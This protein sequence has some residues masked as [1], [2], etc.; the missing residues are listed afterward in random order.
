MPTSQYHFSTTPE[1]Q[2]YTDE[3][4][5]TKLAADKAAK[6]AKKSEVRK[7]LLAMLKDDQTKKLFYASMILCVAS[8]GLAIASPWFLKSVVDSM[9]LGT[10]VNLNAAF[11]GVGA[12]GLTRLL[13]TLIQEARMWD[14][15]K[16]IQLST[17]RIS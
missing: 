9:A 12:F 17:K 6:A 10:Q 5:Q 14:V 13:S 15:S 3:E 8:K 1:S 2:S 16:I 7:K 11:L 4:K